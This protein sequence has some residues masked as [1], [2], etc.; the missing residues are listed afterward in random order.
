[1]KLRVRK[2]PNCGALLALIK[3]RPAG[4]FPCPTCET[5]LVASEYYPLLTLLASLTSA[6]VL[7]A[8]LGF[9]GSDLVRALLLAFIPVLFLSANFFKYLIPPKIEIY[10][11]D[12]SLRLR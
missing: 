11:P 6:T 1:M 8:S 9:R 12:T 3:I 5:L 10:M 7:F 2:C 4:S